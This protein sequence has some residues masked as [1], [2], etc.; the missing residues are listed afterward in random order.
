MRLFHDGEWFDAVPPGALYEHEF[1]GIV[2]Q[3][4]NEL[5]PGFS[6]ARFDPILTTPMG[7][8][9]PDMILVDNHYRSLFV[10]EVELASHSL[11]RH[12]LP[13]VEKIAA[14]RLG[15]R[16]ADWL[17][18]KAPGFDR[19]RLR[20]LFRDVPHGTML[21]VNSPT[22]QWDEGLRS[23]PG[24][25]R[26]VVEV[27]R[28]RHSRTIL[29]INGAQPEGPGEL[30][31]PLVAGTG[32]LRGSYK[33]GVPSAVDESLTEIDVHLDGDLVRFRVKVMGAEKYLFSRPA[34]DVPG[35]Q[36]RLLRST[37]GTYRIEVIK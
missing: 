36:A 18:S 16:Q 10:I 28:S 23:L 26:A 29:R 25:Y 22:P 3:H 31:T 24:V 37:A 17:L 5:F 2:M 30:V 4:Q 7:N 21:L 34:I 13:Q 35:E 1:E 6:G 20:A 32:S 19:G 15:E 27:F 33:I 9:Q 11:A 8:V 14:A 12:V